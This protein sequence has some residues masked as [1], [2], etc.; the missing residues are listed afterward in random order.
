MSRQQI[1]Q[2]NLARRGFGDSAAAQRTI[3]RWSA[4]WT[5]LLELLGDAGDPDL[6]LLGLDRLGDHVDGLFA[7]L[8]AEPVLARQ[9]IMV[10]GGSTRMQQHVINHPQH[11]EHLSVAAGRHTAHEQRTEMLTAVGASPAAHEPVAAGDPDCASNALRIAYLGALLPVI[12]RDLTAADPVDEMPDIAGELSDLAAAVLESALAIARLRS[13][14][15]HTGCHVA[16]IALGKCGG[17]ELNYASDVDVLFVAESEHLD[18]AT[19]LAADVMR[20]C[21]AQTA[22]GSLFQIDAALRPEGNA[23]PLVRT[24]ESHRG[25]YTRWAKGWEFQAMLKSRPVAGDQ[26]LGRQFLQM[27]TPLVWQVAERNHFIGETQRMRQRVIEHIPAHDAQRELKLGE[28]GLRDVEFAVQLLQLVHG[29]ADDRLRVRSTLDGLQALID[30]GYVGRADGSAFG[31]AYRFL[32]ALEHRIQLYRLQRTHVLPSGDTDRRRIGRLMGYPDPAAELVRQWQDTARQVR[33]LHQRL[34]YSPLLDA[35]ANIPSEELR[36]TQQAA[37][38][39]L[40]ALG[41]QDAEAALH[42][43]RALTQGI[44][45]QAEIQRQL[46]PAMLGWFADRPSPDHGLRA[47]RQTSQALKTSP[48]YLRALRDEG[49]MAERLAHVLASSRYAVNLLQRAPEAVQM[50]AEETQLEVRPNAEL[51][52]EM[53]AAV[54][55]QPGSEQAVAAI[56]AIRRRELFRI[57]VADLLD[58]MDVAAVSRA[59][60]DL[61]TVTIDAALQAVHSDVAGTRSGSSPVPALAVIAMGRWGGREMAYGSDADAIFVFDNDAGSDDGAKTGM[62]MIT[63]LRR[64]L[65]L[66]GADP[67]LIIDTGLRPEGRDG[68]LVR[69]LA[70]YENYYRRWSSGW[71]MQALIRAD[72]VAGD[73]D[74][75]R[76]L[77]ATI[78]AVRWPRHVADQQVTQIRRLKARMESERV[79][80]GTDPGK[81]LKFAPGGLADVEW[82]VQLLQLQHARDHPGLQTTQTVAALR[83]ASQANVIDADDADAL[84]SA[85]LL[86]SRI[87]NQVMLVRGRA[88]DTFPSD[89]RELSAVAELLGYGHGQGSHLMADYQRAARRARRVSDHIFWQG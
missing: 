79:P 63:E 23:G 59:L 3:V 86:G 43:I 42:H 28:G 39:R 67:P 1:T 22:A 70:A 31:S 40:Q 5:G 52:S 38:D 35:V 57:A 29:R 33:R 74:L 66:P 19:E 30:Y 73:L 84:E 48:W 88:S 13:G 81:H 64:L 45:R 9:L 76:R 8:S 41:Y 71:E 6:A 36:L 80:R 53:A 20:I 60:S 18:N 47:F 75:G 55:R 16:V 27:I 25:Y 83:A 34:F 17:Q 87:R 44:S 12:A 85:W 24:L 62:Q 61:A 11:L 54:R 65:S 56:R 89:P 58:R 32:R 68:P 10:L 21:S 46:L 72:A 49:A 26:E 50:L 14:P 7:R 37:E 82:T 51:T 78:D 77:I 15:R 4:D 2:G 69:S